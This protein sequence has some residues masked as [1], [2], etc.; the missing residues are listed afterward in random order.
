ML[1][2]GY[3]VTKFERT[4]GSRCANC[5]HSPEAPR[6]VLT[7]PFISSPIELIGGAK[8]IATLPAAVKFAREVLRSRGVIK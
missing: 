1:P 5:G 6:F 2:D 3:A 7:G 8:P 4:T